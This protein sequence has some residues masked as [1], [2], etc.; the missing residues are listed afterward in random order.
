MRSSTSPFLMLSP[1][2]ALHRD[3]R[4]D[5]ETEEQGEPEEEPSAVEP[6]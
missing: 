3:R 2:F 1:A 4:L 5:D 6:S